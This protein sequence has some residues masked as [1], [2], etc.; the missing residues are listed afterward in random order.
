MYVAITQ[1]LNYSEEESKTKQKLQ[2][3]ILT[4]LWPWNK[5]KVTKPWTTM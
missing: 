5:V 3:M 4:N 1:R 2:F